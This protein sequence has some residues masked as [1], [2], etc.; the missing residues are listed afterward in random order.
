MIVTEARGLSR[1][2]DGNAWRCLARRG[3]LHSECEAVDYVRVP[4]GGTRDGRGREGVETAWFVV[5]GQGRFDDCSGRSVPLRAGDVLLSAGA[6][7]TVRNDAAGDLELLALTV[8][9]ATV[10][11]QLPARIPVAQW[12]LTG[13]AHD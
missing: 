9:A 6:P 4:P 10:A 1:A 11:D 12:L 3:M 13:A 5:A 2:T 8:L 7:G